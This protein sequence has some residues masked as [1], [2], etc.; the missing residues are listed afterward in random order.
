[1]SKKKNKNQGKLVKMTLRELMQKLDSGEIMQGPIR[2]ERLS[3]ALEGEV[4]D[5]WLRCA[6]FWSLP[7]FEQF[8]LGFL[9][10]MNPDQEVGAWQ[11]I[12][13]AFEAF[14]G[15]HPEADKA[16]VIT[17][18]VFLSMGGDGPEEM[19]KLLFPNHAKE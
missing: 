17:K 11:R 6:R 2:R 16:Y 18:L 4:R 19:R 8:E 12:A 3:P 15:N 10:D 9:R 1:M 5:V 7:T 13:T 14:M